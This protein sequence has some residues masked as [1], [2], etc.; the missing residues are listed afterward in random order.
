MPMYMNERLLLVEGKRL[1]ASN[2]DVRHWEGGPTVPGDATPGQERQNMAVSV[3]VAS[4]GEGNS[5]GRGLDFQNVERW[6]RI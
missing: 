2:C 3:G 4:R 1:V 6:C 5:V